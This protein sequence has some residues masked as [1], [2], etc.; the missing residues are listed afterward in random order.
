MAWLMKKLCGWVLRGAQELSAKATLRPYDCSSSC[1][2]VF[3][4]S[5]FQAVSPFALPP[6][7]TTAAADGLENSA[8]LVKTRNPSFADKGAIGDELLTLCYDVGILIRRGALL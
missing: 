8:S 5:V 2:S 4:P 1:F 3:P 6:W 7:I